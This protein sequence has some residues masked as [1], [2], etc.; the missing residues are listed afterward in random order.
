MTLPSFLLK[1][2]NTAAYK[3]VYPCMSTFFSLLSRL[4]RISMD[5]FAENHRDQGSKANCK[6][7]EMT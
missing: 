3:H 7:Y 4:K 6:G 2:L 1:V 5:F